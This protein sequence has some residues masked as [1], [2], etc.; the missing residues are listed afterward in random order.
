MRHDTIDNAA[1]DFLEAKGRE[2]DAYHDRI[3]AENRLIALIGVK[4]EGTTSAKTG[5][6]KVATCGRMTYSLDNAAYAAIAARIPESIRDR[7]VRYKAEPVLGE[8]RYLEANEPELY[9]IFAEALT[10]KPAKPSVSV[11]LDAVKRAA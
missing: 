9:A 3:E 1:K 10:I 11:E 4:A 5:T 2:L 7:L 8:L 6:Y